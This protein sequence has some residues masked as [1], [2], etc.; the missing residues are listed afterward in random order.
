MVYPDAKV[1]SANRTDRHDDVAETLLKVILNI[2]YL[3]NKWMQD[4]VMVAMVTRFS[5]ICHSFYMQSAMAVTSLFHPLVK[6]FC[7][8]I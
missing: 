5:V 6:Q 8:N 1:S 2:N 7:F 4:L 3:A